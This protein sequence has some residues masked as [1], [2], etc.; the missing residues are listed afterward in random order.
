MKAVFKLPDETFLEIISY[1]PVISFR[2]SI[3]TNLKSVWYPTHLPGEY[4]ERSNVLRAI[5]QTCRT[6]R[7][8]FL[9]WSWER[10]EACVAPDPTAWYIQ[11]GNSLES[12]C[13]ILLK[14]PLLATYVRSASPRFPC[15]TLFSC[16]IIDSVM[17]V[18]ITRYRM[19]AILPSFANCLQ[20]LPNLQT[21]ELS[22]VHQG[23]TTKVKK[24][25]EGVAI[26]SIRTVVLPTVAHH[27]LRSCPNVEDVTCTDEDGSRLLGTI[28]SNCPKVERI[29]G[30]VLSPVML[31]SWSDSQLFAEPSLL[32]A[33]LPGLAKTNPNIRE[34]SF[35]IVRRS[36]SVPH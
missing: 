36:C 35:F 6:L 4:A 25:F 1:F 17:S 11:L 26:P 2:Y 5:T 14:N 15:S 31:K 32:I 9:S 34:L 10:V 16:V 24:A 19:D 20:S 8:K 30:M 23:M 28:A 7:R 22:H 12:K 18:G 27:I 33:R 21:L 3:D 29:S 13:H